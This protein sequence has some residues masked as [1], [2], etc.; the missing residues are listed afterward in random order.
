MDQDDAKSQ[1]HI[2]LDL[3]AEIDCYGGAEETPAI[4]GDYVTRRSLLFKQFGLP[5]TTVNFQLLDPQAMTEVEMRG[6]NLSGLSDNKRMGEFHQLKDILEQAG[7]IG[8]TEDQKYDLRKERIVNRVFD[9]LY[10]R[11]KNLHKLPRPS[12]MAI[13]EFGKEEKVPAADLLTLLGFFNEPYQRFL[14]NIILYGG[15]STTIQVR[16]E[17]VRAQDLTNV[18]GFVE[19]YSD[20]LW[21]RQMGAKSLKMSGLRFIDSYLWWEKEI[22]FFEHSGSASPK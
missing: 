9:R 1:I 17:L 12:L 14:I 15:Y 8:F 21:E 19:L 3:R 10:L 6:I 4:W 11:A 22:I 20:F 2:L 7:I 13:L 5:E 18:W 16:R